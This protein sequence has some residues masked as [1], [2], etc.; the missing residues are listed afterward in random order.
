MDRNSYY[1]GEVRDFTNFTSLII[2]NQSASLNLEQLYEKFR[3]GA[4]VNPICVSYFPLVYLLLQAFF[5]IIVFSF[6][7]CLLL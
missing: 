6:R 2:L 3:G 4:K 7:I 1:G 5:R